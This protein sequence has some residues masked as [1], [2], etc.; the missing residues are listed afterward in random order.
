LVFIELTNNKI[1]KI[2]NSN[3]FV[4][5]AI[6]ILLSLFS[7]SVDD[8]E[9]QSNV[10][11]TEEVR[12]PETEVALSGWQVEVRDVTISTTSTSQKDRYQNFSSYVFMK[13]VVG[14][15]KTSPNAGGPRCELE[16]TSS[17]FRTS[18]SR[19]MNSSMKLVKLS[20]RV[21]LGQIF[22][23][24]ANDDLAQIYWK[25]NNIVADINGSTKVLRSN[26]GNG[27]SITFSM[28]TSAGK[29][30]ITSNG[31]SHSKTIS[32]SNL[33]FK[34]GVYV[35]GGSNGNVAEINLYSATK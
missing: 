19:T 9:I 23:D 6:C 22:D 33:K 11:P 1:F 5:G 28:K 10:L 2:M 34:T 12:G 15:A 24:G 32:A 17:Y 3:K 21:V 8:Q 16:S 4:W 25:S 30:T 13:A 18:D 7:C 31:V 14:D 35:V 29:V 26:V 27:A 20:N